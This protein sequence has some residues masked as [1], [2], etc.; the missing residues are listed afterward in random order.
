M[1]SRIISTLLLV[2]LSVAALISEI[3]WADDSDGHV[4]IVFGILSAAL[5][6]ANWL[7]WDT[8]RAG[9]NSGH[10]SD[11]EGAKLPSLAWSWPLYVNA[12]YNLWRANETRQP[13]SDDRRRTG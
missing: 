2:L 8:I 4:F 13:G 3:T 11:K 10:T 1:I 5:A 9:W 7:L 12:L 6:V